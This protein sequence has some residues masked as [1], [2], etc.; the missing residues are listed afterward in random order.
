MYWNFLC[1]FL[2]LDSIKA[3]TIS[4]CDLCF[5]LIRCYGIGVGVASRG[6]TVCHL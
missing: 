5:S 3:N 1:C 4:V 2:S 6:F